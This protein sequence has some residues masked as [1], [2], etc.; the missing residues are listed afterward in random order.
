MK[1]RMRR[2]GMTVTIYAL[3]MKLI[4]EYSQERP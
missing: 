2:K 3:E 4:R 1:S